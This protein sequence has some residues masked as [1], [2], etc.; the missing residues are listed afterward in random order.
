M[1]IHLVFFIPKGCEKRK[2]KAPNHYILSKMYE[3]PIYSAE[4][5]KQICNSGGT[6]TH[7]DSIFMRF[8]PFLTTILREKAR[9]V[10]LHAF[11]SC[12]KCDYAKL[13]RI[14]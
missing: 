7:L 5:I 9:K 13:L 3:A 11:S 12:Q 6:G 1:Q 10:E 8:F 4:D 14:L 2:K